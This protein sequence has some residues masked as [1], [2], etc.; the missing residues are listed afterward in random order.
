MSIRD[1]KK[2][3]NYFVMLP[4]DPFAAIWDML[5]MLFILFVCITSP[6]RIA[7]SDSDN[8]TWTVIGLVV[9]AFFLADLLLNF[10]T[11]YYDKEYNLVINRKVRA[12]FVVRS[13]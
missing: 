2:R 10:F 7:Y 6:A 5:N 11:A 8:T 12:L 9:D 13:V 4:S 1:D 3:P